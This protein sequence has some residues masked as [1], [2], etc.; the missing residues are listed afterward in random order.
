[1]SYHKFIKSLSLLIGI[2]IFQMS[3]TDLEVDE[4]ESIITETETGAF[5]GDAKAL[6]ES[7]Y[8]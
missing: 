3:C 8:N 5:T 2:G 4:M 6:L 7:A 1:M